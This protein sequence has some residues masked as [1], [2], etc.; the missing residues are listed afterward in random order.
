MCSCI[1]VP[2]SVQRMLAKPTECQLCDSSWKP[3]RERGGMTSAHHRARGR[4][5]HGGDGQGNRLLQ[6][7][8]PGT[9]KHTDDS[10]VSDALL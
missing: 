5:R 9:W 7:S 10:V 1:H 6:D 4:E 8:P 3:H 2:T